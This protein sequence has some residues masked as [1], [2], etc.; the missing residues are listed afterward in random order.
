MKIDVVMHLV[1]MKKQVAS[2]VGACR[3]KHISVIPMGNIVLSDIDVRVAISVDVVQAPS[4]VVDRILADCPIG[5]GKN[6]GIHLGHR[7]AQSTLVLDGYISICQ[8]Q[9]ADT[10]RAAAHGVNQC[11]DL[12]VAPQIAIRSILNNSV[13]AA[14]NRDEVSTRNIYGS[15]SRPIRS[16]QLGARL[17]ENS[18][19]IAG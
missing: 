2:A 15:V 4:A 9:I 19:W 11:R 14:V 12:A 18:D 5:A 1:V 13:C 3:C 16:I 17:E 6:H 8:R 7:T 10:A